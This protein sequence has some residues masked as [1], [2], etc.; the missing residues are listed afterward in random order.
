MTFIPMPLTTPNK[1]NGFGWGLFNFHPEMRI[2]VREQGARVTKKRSVP[3]YV[4]I[5]RQP[6]NAAFEQKDCLRMGTK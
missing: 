4:S 5:L 2:Y 6:S 3:E 1:N